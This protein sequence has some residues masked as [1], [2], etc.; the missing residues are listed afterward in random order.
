[1]LYLLAQNSRYFS[2]KK[3]SGDDWSQV[4]QTIISNYG[5]TLNG[6]MTADGSR[7]CII[8]SLD[9]LIYDLQS[10]SKGDTIWVNRDHN[11]ID[12]GIDLS[13]HSARVRMKFNSMDGSRLLF[14]IEPTAVTKVFHYDTKQ[15]TKS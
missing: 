3:T 14:N 12:P 7:L 6:A 2:I 5:A 10:N 8:H 13:I 1:M 11:K 9:V 15:T 4:G